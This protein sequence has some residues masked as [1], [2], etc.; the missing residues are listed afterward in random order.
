MKQLLLFRHAKSS[1]KDVGLADFDRPLNKRGKR[2]APRMGKLI[3]EMGFQ[4]D[5]IISSSA[6]RAKDTIIAAAKEFEFDGEIQ[7]TR[8]LYGA[9]PEIYFELL[10]HLSAK[11]R[12]V[13]MVGHN[14]EMENLLEMLIG[15][16]ERFPTAAL[17]VVD[18][19]IKH[20]P[21][22]LENQAGKLAGIWRPKEIEIHG[23]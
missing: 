14:P 16:Y 5:V 9:Y 18:L 3:K 17:A 20:W 22:I 15:Y 10:S 4:P 19:D 12:S 21:E 8:D 13:M 7:F 2:D 23:S 6:K 1:W 11:V